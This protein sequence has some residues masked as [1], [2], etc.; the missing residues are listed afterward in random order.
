MSQECNDTLQIK[1][2]ISSFS[3][4]VLLLSWISFLHMLWF[5]EDT[6]IILISNIQLPFIN[7][8]KEKNSNTS[9][10][11]GIIFGSLQ[12]FLGSDFYHFPPAWTASQSIYCGLGLVGTFSHLLLSKNV[13]SPPPFEWWRILGY[14]LFS[15]WYLFILRKRFPWWPLASE[16]GW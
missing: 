5:P 7:T 11:R 9:T 8:R 15:F 14:F 1:P 6:V 12:S 16:P 3:P 2:H 10:H 4:F 13:L